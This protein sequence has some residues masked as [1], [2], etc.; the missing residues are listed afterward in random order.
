MFHAPMDL[1]VWSLNLLVSRQPE[2]ALAASDAC[3]EM[4]PT[5]HLG[6]LIRGLALEDLG[7]EGEA[8]VECDKAFDGNP[9][10]RKVFTPVVSTYLNGGTR[11]EMRAEVQK[12]EDMG[13]I[14]FVPA[15][16]TLY[17]NRFEPRAEMLPMGI[18]APHEEYYQAWMA[19]LRKNTEHVAPLNTRAAAQLEIVSALMR[20]PK[21]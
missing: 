20:L 21:S 1:M 2:L 19:S 10:L 15:L 6:H 8:R 13:V 14:W 5:Y 11:E 12:L 3:L 16:W 17:R 9:F 4:S 7:R 18:Y